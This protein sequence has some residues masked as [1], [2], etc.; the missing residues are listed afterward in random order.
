MAMVVFA[1]TSFAVNFKPV[2]AHQMTAEGKAK[3]QQ[4]FQEFNPNKLAEGVEVIA[5]R[6][7][8]DQN[9]TTW[10]AELL[11]YGP[12]LHE[13]FLGE[14]EDRA[15]FAELPFYEV[16]S[17]MYSLNAEGNAYDNLYQALLCWPST[18][19][20]GATDDPSKEAAECISIQDL[21]SEGYNT[22]VV[23]PQGYL[24]SETNYG[25]L[26]AQWFGVPSLFKGKQGYMDEDSFFT[27]SN[28]DKDNS[29]IDLQWNGTWSEEG[30]T[31]SA[32]SFAQKFSGAANIQGFEQLN[33]KGDFTEIHFYDF[34]QVDWD[35]YPGDLY[36]LDFD[37]VKLY[38]FLAHNAAIEVRYDAGVPAGFTYLSETGTS[39]DI[40]YMV[41]S[42]YTEL[43]ATSPEGEYEIQEILYD[44][45]TGYLD[46]VPL[47]GTIIPYHSGFEPLSADGLSVYYHGN[48]YNLQPGG[49]MVISGAGFTFD[50]LDAYSNIWDVDF[51]KCF[52]HNDPSDYTKSV[53]LTSGINRLFGD[54]SANL[55][56]KANGCVNVT[57]AEDGV[58][59]VYSTTGALVKTV[60]AVAGQQV[61]IELGNG[62]YIVKVGKTAAK[63]I[64]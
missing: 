44:P 11:N 28:Y 7:Y 60:K 24:M 22:F 42:A 23:Q 38:K 53:E 20:V 62:L 31:S 56:T 15:T 5:T 27:F 19:L 12:N 1:A 8:V 18:Y 59:A 14:S 35:T 13:Y 40:S 29:T 51:S 36:E 34:G 43:N 48:G 37:P 30:A 64:L 32:G 25:I 58:I 55:V 45:V 39:T 26:N 63:V 6:S 50:A 52:I 10:Y 57:A 3:V 16:L 4:H 47:P 41:G 61:S 21:I 17:V 9:G 46:N 49:K 33:I 54:K 2:S